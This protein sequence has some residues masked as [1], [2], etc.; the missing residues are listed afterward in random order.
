MEGNRD[1]ENKTRGGNLVISL[2]YIQQ[3]IFCLSL[4]EESFRNFKNVFESGVSVVKEPA[5][6]FNLPSYR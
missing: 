4:M 3:N 6:L 5:R 1:L 2:I